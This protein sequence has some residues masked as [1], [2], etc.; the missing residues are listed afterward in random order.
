MS[1]L[2]GSCWTA[3][4]CGPP[5]A[6]RS[7]GVSLQGSPQAVGLRKQW[8]RTF[9][10]STGLPTTRWRCRNVEG[11]ATRK[12]RRAFALGASYAS[13]PLLQ[14][15]C[16]GGT[17]RAPRSGAQGDAEEQWFKE[18]PG[19]VRLGRWPGGGARAFRPVPRSR[20]ALP[21]CCGVRQAS[22]V[23]RL[24]DARPVPAAVPVRA[25]RGARPGTCLDARP[26]PVV[27]PGSTPVPAPGSG[28]AQRW[29]C[30]TGVR[31]PRGSVPGVASVSGPEQA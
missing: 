5:R 23:R 16:E 21:A 4:S 20:T 28:P 1:G 15:V 17:G 7:T 24:C 26:V 6:R 14:G 25:C 30:V 13:S 22:F 11:P 31:A 19:T 8:T 18:R 2:S 9:G 3:T 29:S 27:V 10:S 12:S